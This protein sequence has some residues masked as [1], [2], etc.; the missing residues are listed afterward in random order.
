MSRTG[1]DDRSVRATNIV[2]HPTVV[3][4]AEREARLGQHGRLIW[5]TG[6]SGSGKSTI[7]NATEHRLHTMGRATYLLD[8]DN[9]R[10]GLC[11]DLGFDQAS[12]QENI[13]R[14]AEVGRLFVD[15]GLIVLAAFISPLREDREFVRSRVDAGDFLEVFVDVPLDVCEARDPKGLYRRAR[16]GEIASF[17]GISA[18]Y[19]APE[20][21]E[22]HLQPHGAPVDEAVDR[23]VAVLAQFEQDDTR[24]LL[25]RPTS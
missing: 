25:G 11:R 13:R 2:W 21:P 19:E 22:V 16:R 24:T 4:R 15:A 18:P 7:A 20:S 5:F 9:L 10:H 17:T 3:R 14:I 6:L 23:V 1:P 12:R 8:G